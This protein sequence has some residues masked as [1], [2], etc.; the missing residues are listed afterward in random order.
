MRLG[1]RGIA[2]IVVVLLLGLSTAGCHSGSGVIN[3]APTASPAL[4]SSSASIT[5][6]PS[7]ATDEQR[8]LAQYQS[9]WKREAS[10]AEAAATQRRAILE[11]VATDPLLSRVLRGMQASDNLG[12]IGYGRI[13]PRARVTGIDRDTATIRDCQDASKAGRKDRDTGK[14]VTRGTAHDLALAT[15]K[16]GRDGVWRV[17]TVDYP[18]GDRC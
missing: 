1:T 8:I 10:A 9:F 17:A 12:Q 4:G 18:R 11:A 3:D 2:A 7:V 5:A 15:M 13:I 14:T 6:M 16:R